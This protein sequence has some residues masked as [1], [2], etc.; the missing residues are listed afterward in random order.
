MI[1]ILSRFFL[2]LK[3][4]LLL[5]WKNNVKICTYIVVVWEYI[6]NIVNSSS[7]TTVIRP[8]ALYADV[9]LIHAD[10]NVSE[11]Y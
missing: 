4:L 6:N 1:F 5:Q 3:K 11:F 7:K 10:D 8:F 9:E 2:E